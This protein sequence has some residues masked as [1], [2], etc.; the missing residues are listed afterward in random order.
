MPA[1]PPTPI[2]VTDEL[3]C[4]IRDGQKEIVNE[5]RALRTEIRG[6]TGKGGKR[7]KEPKR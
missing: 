3:L 6:P 2:T 4:D 7:L 1:I 5:L